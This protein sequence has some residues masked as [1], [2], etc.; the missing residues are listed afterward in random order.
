MT[1]EKKSKPAK[2]EKI[3]K[4]EKI[5]VSSVSKGRIYEDRAAEYLKTRGYQIRERNFRCFYGEIDLI[6]QKGNDLFF[7]EVK[8]QKQDYQAEM[9]INRAKRQR[10]LA[11]SA[12][13]LRR[14]NLWRDY[15]VHYDVVIVTGG[16]IRYYADA[17]EW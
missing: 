16:Q 2:I 6:A 17:F 5:T 8:G 3:A 13:Y 10:I 4:T 15:A 12:E 1:D 7:I 11:A 14:Q 9:K